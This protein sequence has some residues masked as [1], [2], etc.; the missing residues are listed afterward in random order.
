M[1]ET[2]VCIT[3][4]TGFKKL[5]VG[6]R[7]TFKSYVEDLAALAD[8]LKA[9]Q[10]FVVGVSGGGPYAYAAAHYLPDR[11]RGVMT[12]STLPPSGQPH[13]LERFK[14]LLGVQMSP[15]GFLCA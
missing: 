14:F 5:P 9:A 1:P 4:R 15:P 7:R 8:H 13:V 6:A 2:L 3:L 12:I 10:F 11:V